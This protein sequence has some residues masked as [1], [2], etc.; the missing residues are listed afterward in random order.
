MNRVLRSGTAGA[1]AI[2][3]CL[4]L[5]AGCGSSTSAESGSGGDIHIGM[6]QSLTGSLSAYGAESEAGFKFVIDKVNAAGG[7][8]SLGGAKIDLDVAD[9]ASDPATAATAL[10]ELVGSNHDAM[11]VGTLLTDQM[12]AVSPVADRFKVPVLS[13]FAGGSN[14]DYLYSLGLPYGPGYAETFAEFIKYLNTTDDAGIKTAALA[15]S[16]YEAGQAVD[17]ELGPRLTAEGIDVLGDVPL[18]TGGSDYKPAVTKLDAMNPDVVTGLVTTQDGVTLHQARAALHSPLLYVGG[19]GGYADQSVWDSLGADVAPQVLAKNTF[20]MTTFSASAKEPALQS[21]L[22]EATAA[23]L[24]VPIGQNFVQGAQAAWVVDE[25][26]ENAGSNDSSAIL[27][28]FSKVNIPPKSDEL[29]MAR[30]DGISFDPATRFMKNPTAIVVQWNADGTQ[31]VVWPQEL[32]AHKPEL[33]R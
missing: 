7:V 29:Y 16:D 22:K 24:K 3:S 6:L 10:R 1:V 18:E 26:L 20:A 4:A 15:S 5:A 25:V 14:S 23:N 27:S 17:K 19:T 33:D 2:G 12:A 11:V 32:A 31:D 30:P 9:D 13:E 8:K 21:L 28:A